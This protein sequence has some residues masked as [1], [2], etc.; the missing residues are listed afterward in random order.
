MQGCMLS[1][2]G[3]Y[4]TPKWEAVARLGLHAWNLSYQHKLDD[5]FVVVTDLEGSIMQVRVIPSYLIRR[6]GGVLSK[7]VCKHRNILSFII[8]CYPCEGSFGYLSFC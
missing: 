4:A 2:G 6:C 3:A 1:V 5:T 8:F 7:R